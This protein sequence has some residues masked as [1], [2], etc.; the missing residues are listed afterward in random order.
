[1]S[2]LRRTLDPF[3]RAG[4]IDV[5]LAAIVVAMHGVLLFN[6]LLHHPLVGYDAWGYLT[7][8]QA[9]SEGRFPTPAESHEFFSPPLPFAPVA[10]T[11]A[12]ARSAGLDGL[13]AV[14][15]GGKVLQLINVLCS[16]VLV[17]QLLRLCEF[18]RPGD[19]V[20]KRTAVLLLASLPVY[21]KSFAMVRAE[22][23]LAMLCLLAV[24]QVIEIWERRVWSLRR[25]LLLGTTLG[26][27]ALTRQWGL[28]LIP[29]LL[30]AALGRP[31]ST[32]KAAG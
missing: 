13:G 12:V 21:Y 7:Y 32:G 11:A 3:R 19:F 24:R 22:P 10:A 18:L 23:M 9:L 28:M 14:M 25:A 15:L 17:Q 29:A 4:R 2:F 27:A 1:M 16:L 26:L 8:A 5:L 30:V 31:P 20:L 6:A